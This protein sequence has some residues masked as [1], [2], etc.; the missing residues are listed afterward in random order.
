[1]M[2]RL[3]IV[4]V[5]AAGGLAR[6]WLPLKPLRRGS[7]ERPGGGESTGK[8][9]DSPRRRREA[10]SDRRLA[11]RQQP[12]RHLGRGQLRSRR[13]R[14]RPRSVGAGRS[15]VAAGRR[16]PAPYQPWAAQ[17]VLESFNKR[18]IDDPTRLVPAAGDSAHRHARAF[19]E[20]IVQTPQADRDSLRVHERLPR[21]SAERE[22]SRRYD[23]D[24][25]GQL[26][27]P[28]GGDTLVVD[29]IG[30][31]DKTWLT[32]PGRSTPTRCT[33]PSATRASTRTGSTT[34]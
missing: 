27:R 15:R 7:P 3:L 34:K 31:N 20:Q 24:L 2:R 8:S 11:G 10:R 4:I 12:A 9:G 13:R 32:A 21:D 5:V 6:R 29:V 1:M 26:G 33:S 23:S 17:K 14:H 16:D 30:F 19:P 28:L 25:Y 22:A 18:G